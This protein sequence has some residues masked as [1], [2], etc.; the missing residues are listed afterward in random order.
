MSVAPNNSGIAFLVK[1]AVA[2]QIAG[3]KNSKA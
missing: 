1:L 3:T 2:K